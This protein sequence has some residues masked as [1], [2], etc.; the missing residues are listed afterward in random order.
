MEEHLSAYF[1]MKEFKSVSL[2]RKRSAKSVSR[3][4][5]QIFELLS[6]QKNF[7]KA[8]ENIT[9]IELHSPSLDMSVQLKICLATPKFSKTGTPSACDHN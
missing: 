9:Q 7:H 8:N 2:K 4:E 1:L 5:C 6:H 3:I